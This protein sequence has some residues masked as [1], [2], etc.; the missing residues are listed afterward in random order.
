V[1]ERSLDKLPQASQAAA[2]LLPPTATASL[3]LMTEDVWVVNVV[4]F[5]IQSRKNTLIMEE[6]TFRIV[7]FVM[8]I[9][10]Y[11]YSIN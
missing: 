9:L 5:F 11:Q 7:K 6:G 10:D 2:L 8:Q 4:I 1:R 3:E